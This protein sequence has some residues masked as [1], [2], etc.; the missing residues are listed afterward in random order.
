MR[1]LIAVTLAAALLAGCAG[2]GSR[3]VRRSVDEANVRNGAGNTGAAGTAAAGPNAN[4]QSVTEA[5][6]EAERR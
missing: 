1:E 4:S 5:A 6:R 3:P 2:D